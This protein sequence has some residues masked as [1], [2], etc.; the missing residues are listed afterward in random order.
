MFIEKTTLGWILFTRHW[1]TES[2][3]SVWPPPC[4]VTGLTA[5]C[6]Y[7][8]RCCREIPGKYSE[9]PRRA[10]ALIWAHRGEF[11]ATAG[12]GLTG[13]W[14]HRHATPWFPRRYSRGHRYSPHFHM[15]FVFKEPLKSSVLSAVLLHSHGLSQK[16]IYCW[17]KN[18]LCFG[19][20][21]SLTWGSPFFIV[22]L[23][24]SLHNTHWSDTWHKGVCHLSSPLVSVRSAATVHCTVS[25]TCTIETES[26]NGKQL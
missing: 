3:G 7:S 22:D 18:M 16:I 19:D 10:H 15:D 13:S 12:P 17:E 14:P 4:P 21:Q 20:H 6:C 2:R 24:S 5:S 9:R 26:R 25:W 1:V 11:P 23:L 8:R